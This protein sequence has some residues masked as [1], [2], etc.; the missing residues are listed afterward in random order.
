MLVVIL[1]LTTFFKK[2]TKNKNRNRDKNKT[3]FFNNPRSN[4]REREK[5]A[6]FLR[7]SRITV[8]CKTNQFG[9]YVHMHVLYLFPVESNATSKSTYSVNVCYQQ[10]IVKYR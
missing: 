6:I 2:N 5:F 1:I 9:F 4:K 7:A 3:F 10:V 8:L